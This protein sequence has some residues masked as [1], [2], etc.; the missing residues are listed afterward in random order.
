MSLSSLSSTTSRRGRSSLVVVR[1]SVTTLT[2]LSSRGLRSRSTR[3]GASIRSRSHDS[4]PGFGVTV[5]A[6]ATIGLLIVI[7]I[8]IHDAA[9]ILLLSPQATRLAGSFHSPRLKALAL[10]P[11]NTLEPQLEVLALPLGTRNLNMKRRV[12]GRRW[13]NNPNKPWPAGRLINDSDVPCHANTTKST[14]KLLTSPANRNAPQSPG[15]AL[16]YS[17]PKSSSLACWK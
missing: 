3:Q 12:P 16:R 17:R 2:L 13:M 8:H 15:E 7:I 9:G 10:A 6:L 11:N 1:T 4:I 5:A 14:W